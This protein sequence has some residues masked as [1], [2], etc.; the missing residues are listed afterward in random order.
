MNQE[1]EQFDKQLDTYAGA[2]NWKRSTVE[3]EVLDLG[4]YDVIPYNEF[5]N[6]MLAI[7]KEFRA[8]TKIDMGDSGYTNF[9]VTYMRPETDVEFRERVRDVVESALAH[10]AQVTIRELAQLEELQARYGNL[11]IRTG[12]VP[13]PGVR[14]L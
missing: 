11:P 7:P 8:C 9:N 6:K 4:T 14:K 1:A 2:W 13:S 12:R 5:M 3:V 10:F